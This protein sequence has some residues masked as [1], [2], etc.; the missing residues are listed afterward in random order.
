MPERIQN[1]LNKIRDWWKKFSTKQKAAIIS[2]AVVVVVALIILGNVMSRPTYVALY[3]AK[4]TKEASSVKSLLDGDST[5]DYQVSPDGLVF[6]VNRENLSS[7]RLLLGANDF[8]AAGYSIND[9]VSGSFTT[10][11]ADKQKKYLYLLEQNMQK[12]LESMA[13]VKSARVTFKLPADDGTLAAR[14]APAFGEAILTLQSPI[15]YNQASTIAK[16]MAT[17]LGSKTTENIV[18][19]DSEGNTLYAGGDEAS[20]Y[21]MASANSTVKQQREAVEAAKVRDI[22]SAA[23]V[24]GLG[25]FDNTKIAV[26]LDMDFDDTERTTYDYSVDEGRE[27][28]Y[29]DTELHETTD[30]TNGVAGTPGTDAND[31]TTYVLQDNNY[32]TSSS[33]KDQ[34]KRLPDEQITRTKNEVGK[35]NLENSSISVVAY[36]IDNRYQE[37]LE[38]T[39]QLEGTTWEQYKE[40]NKARQVVEVGDEIYTA[41]S[42]ATGIPV[43]NIS[44]VAYSEPYFI[45]RQAGRSLTEWLEIILAVFILLLLAFVVIRTLRSAKEEAQEEE[46]TVETLLEATPDEALEDIGYQD[47][48]EARKLIEKF[49]DENPEAVAALL[50]NWLNEDWG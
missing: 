48:S 30:A 43:A 46:V 45:N 9:V 27:E 22:L 20:S 42:R 16:V 21:G 19:A 8:P 13:P 5:I 41:V 18:I 17:A 4:D 23:G 26:A 32:S 50:R 37:V 14:T 25:V 39:G 38:A 11:E 28:G 24:D 44:I 6:T 12:D 10:T 1:I 15:S 34:I 35:V 7:A 49:V 29:I 3:T 2:A 40:D 36:N 33:T 47:K 31:D